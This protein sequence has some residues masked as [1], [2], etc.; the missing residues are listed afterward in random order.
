MHILLMLLLITI[1]FLSLYICFVTGSCDTTRPDLKL[2]PCTVSVDSMSGP[3][4]LCRAAGGPE[5]VP[6]GDLQSHVARWAL[7]DRDLV[8]TGVRPPQIRQEILQSN[9]RN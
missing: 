8:Q 5:P 9:H 1:V 2:T 7:C 4:H 6:A 3:S